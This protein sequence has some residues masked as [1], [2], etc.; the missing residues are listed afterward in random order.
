MKGKFKVCLEYHLG[1]CKG[2]CEGLQTEQDYKYQIAQLKN[3]MK[4]NLNRDCVTLDRAV[5]NGV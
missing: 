1:N 2:P 5:R 3:F 4:G